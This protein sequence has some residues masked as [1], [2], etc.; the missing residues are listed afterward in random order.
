MF[1][2]TLYI[3]TSLML[4]L[5]LGDNSVQYERTR[6]RLLI[7]STLS[8]LLYTDG[9]QRHYFLEIT[10]GTFVKLSVK[11]NLHRFV[12]IQRTF[13]CRHQARSQHTVKRENKFATVLP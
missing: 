11:I 13:K 2:V 3:N 10:N 8:E 4:P 7:M 5:S 6:A 9:R 12:S 1:P